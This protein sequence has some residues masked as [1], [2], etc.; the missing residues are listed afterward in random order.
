MKCQ[1]RNVKVILATLLFAVS[2]A[3]ASAK[4]VQTRI[5]GE[6]S[7]TSGG[8]VVTREIG[9][10]SEP[11]V[12]VSPLAFS[13]LPTLEAPC[14]KWSVHGLRINI[15]AGRHRDVAGF[16]FA[17]LGNI[18]VEDFD[19]LQVAGLWNSIGCSDGAIQ[20]AGVLNRCDRDFTGLQA[21]FLVNIAEGTCEGVQIAPINRAI[22]LS[23]L[24]L[25]IYNNIDRGAGTQIGIINYARS[26]EGLQ[27]GAINIIG[28]STIPFC[29]FVNFAF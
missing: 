14:D 18:T 26:L 10:R 7:A 11:A 2:A 29:P 17:G 15:L 16:D 9:E 20:L 27:I 23:G 6:S 24:Q 1:S 19:G 8:G 3:T 5:F 12:G 4:E 28:D 13:I 25:G 21:A 22:D